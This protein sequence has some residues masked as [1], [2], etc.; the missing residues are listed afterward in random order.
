ML[1]STERLRRPFV[2]AF[3]VFVVS[4]AAATALILRLE[5]GRLHEEREPVSL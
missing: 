1:D 4:V 5:Q 3:L 2:V